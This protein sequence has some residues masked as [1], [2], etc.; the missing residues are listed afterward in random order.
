MGV[1]LGWFKGEFGEDQS[2]IL[3]IGVPFCLK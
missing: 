3:P 2:K 1:T